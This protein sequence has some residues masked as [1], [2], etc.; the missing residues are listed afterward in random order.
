MNF[1]PFGLF[2]RLPHVERTEKHSSLLEN[3]TA[4]PPGGV[5]STQGAKTFSVEGKWLIFR[6]WNRFQGL[7][8]V[9]AEAGN[10][11]Q[12]PRINVSKALVELDRVERERRKMENVL[13]RLL[14]LSHGSPR[15]DD[16]ADEIE[17]EKKENILKMGKTWFA[18]CV[19]LDILQRRRYTEEYID[20]Q[21]MRSI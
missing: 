6:S 18:S 19:P 5:Q 16:V 4:A 11:R 13:H 7:A 17:A 20:H 15:Q 10:R 3:T 8:M 9:S 1:K 14:W 21:E 12:R 2:Q